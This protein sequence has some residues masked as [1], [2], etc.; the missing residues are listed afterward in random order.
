MKNGKCLTKRGRD[1]QKPN[2][3]RPQTTWRP[4]LSWH[5][6]PYG[7]MHGQ[8]YV[9]IAEWELAEKIAFSRRVPIEALP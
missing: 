7:L 6:G 1:Q 9:T 8:Y 3:P 5:R 4:D 2:P